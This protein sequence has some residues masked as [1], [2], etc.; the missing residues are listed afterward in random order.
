MNKRSQSLALF[1]LL[2]LLSILGPW[3]TLAQ[4]QPPETIGLPEI[5]GFFFN[6]NPNEPLRRC[7]LRLTG[8]ALRVILVVALAGAAIFVAWAGLMYVGVV[9]GKPEDAKTKII[10]AAVGLVI[11]FMAWAGTALISLLLQ[12]QQGVQ[13]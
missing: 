13:I 1:A 8:L 3:F 6:C 4:V 2:S 7:L 9:G 11:A 10:Y 5:P 12:G